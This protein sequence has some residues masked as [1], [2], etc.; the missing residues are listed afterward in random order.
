MA[1]PPKLMKTSKARN[2]QKE[3]MNPLEV[4]I[5]ITPAHDQHQ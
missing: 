2:F 1:L 3:P 5:A 4:E